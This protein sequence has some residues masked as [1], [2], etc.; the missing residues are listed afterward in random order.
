MT[1]T[2]EVEVRTHGSY[3]SYLA[4]GEFYLDKF[5]D[6]IF[7]RVG[8]INKPEES[9]Q[10]I[11]IWRKT[12]GEWGKASHAYHYILEV[13]SPF[14][15]SIV[16]V[17]NGKQSRGEQELLFSPSFEDPKSEDSDGEWEITFPD[18]NRILICGPSGLEILIKDFNP[19]LSKKHQIPD[20]EIKSV[21]VSY[22][23]ETPTDFTEDAV[24]IDVVTVTS[25]SSTSKQGGL[26]IG[27]QIKIKI[28]FAFACRLQSILMGE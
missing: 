2:I 9:P 6:S 21:G 25:S 20:S 17:G 4:Y 13:E 23:I 5:G 18:A 3:S 14:P 10:G 16:K 7:N 11:K 27:S 19:S 1:I 8:Y 22:W 26:Y 12:S 28:P 24:K 15:Y